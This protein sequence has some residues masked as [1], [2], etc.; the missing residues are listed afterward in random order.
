MVPVAIPVMINL[1][2]QSLASRY[3]AGTLTSR[4]LAAE[5]ATRGTEDMWEI[6]NSCTYVAR[7]ARPTA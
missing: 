7:S 5:I 6:G 1:D 4:A 2:L 3:R